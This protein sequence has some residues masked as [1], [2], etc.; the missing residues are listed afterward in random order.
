M[1]LF[2]VPRYWYKIFKHPLSAHCADLLS[3]NRGIQPKH[4]VRFLAS[5]KSSVSVCFIAVAIAAVFIESDSQS[6]VPV[7][8][9]VILQTAAPQVTQR[10]TYPHNC[11]C[12]GE[13][14]DLHH[15]RVPFKLE[16]G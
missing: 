3:N 7:T 14:K 15:S 16:V 8:R 9:G 5:M 10:P 13:C 2:H 12:K 1:E 6:I 11:D 4:R